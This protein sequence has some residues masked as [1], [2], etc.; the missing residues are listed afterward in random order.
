[1][2]KEFLIKSLN[3]NAA[4]ALTLEKGEDRMEFQA[5][6]LSNFAESKAC[7]GN[8]YW[9]VCPKDVPCPSDSPDVPPPTQVPCPKLV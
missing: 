8:E 3:L 2:K 6:L 5:L 7:T 1:M 9:V 4:E